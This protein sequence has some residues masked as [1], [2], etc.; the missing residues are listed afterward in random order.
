M[1]VDR[2]LI[3]NTMVIPGSSDS[4]QMVDQCLPGFSVLQRTLQSDVCQL[5]CDNWLCERC[6]CCQTQTGRLKTRE[7]L[8][9]SGGDMNSWSPTEKKLRIETQ[10]RSQ[11]R[12][13]RIITVLHKMSKS[14]KAPWKECVLL[15][16]F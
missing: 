3:P 8:R 1:I 4:Q 12:S 11:P 14:K 10:R 9:S 5:P 6:R 16:Q 15:G 7:E 2:A 13:R